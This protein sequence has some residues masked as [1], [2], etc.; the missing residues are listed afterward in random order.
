MSRLLRLLAPFVYPFLIG[1]AGGE[2]PTDKAIAS[3][4]DS[5]SNV[6]YVTKRVLDKCSEKGSSCDLKQAEGQYTKARTAYMTY[7]KAFADTCGAGSPPSINGLAD[8][9]A[10][11]SAEYI[12]FAKP[13]SGTAGG[14][15]DVLGNALSAENL[16][17]IA[18]AVTAYFQRIGSDC[19]SEQDRILERYSW[20]TWDEIAKSK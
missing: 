8:K 14:L 19:K 15:F 13:M 7:L 5:K 18:K 10:S 4:S 11:A 20:K 17:S 2:N 16:R 12:V 3:L 6:E 1:V 9:A